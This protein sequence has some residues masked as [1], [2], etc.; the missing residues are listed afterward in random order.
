MPALSTRVLT[1]LASYVI[2]LYRVDR[3]VPAKGVAIDREA[4]F[5]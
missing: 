2:S 1:I 3:M 4:T 5:L